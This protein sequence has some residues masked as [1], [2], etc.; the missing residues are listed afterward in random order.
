MSKGR[1]SKPL[2][3]EFKAP[4]PT[5][6]SPAAAPKKCYGPHGQRT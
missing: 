4:E 1:K 6:N 3:Q 2:A 5:A